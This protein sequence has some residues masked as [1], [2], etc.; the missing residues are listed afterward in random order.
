MTKRETIMKAIESNE[1]KYKAHDKAIRDINWDLE[2]KEL[3][4]EV[5]EILKEELK[6][7]MEARKNIGQHLN[8][9]WTE[10]AA[11]NAEEN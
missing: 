10:I 11:L 3:D 7:H 2:W 6:S 8:N 1:I 9:L 5:A 4:S